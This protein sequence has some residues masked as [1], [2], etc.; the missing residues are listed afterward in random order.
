MW[1][2]VTEQFRAFVAATFEDL[3]R[4]WTLS[5]AQEGKLPFEPE[6]VGS[7]WAAD[8]QVDVVALDW[9]TKQILL[10][11]AKW[12]EG[13]VGREVI[14][15]L[16]AKTP[17][18][19]PDGGAGWRVYYAFFA[20]NGFTQAAREEAQPYAAQLLTW[21]EMEQQLKV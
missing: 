16:I 2:S 8:A 9:R 13:Q 3:C 4:T 18:V 1:A 21:A 12:G 6:V 5:Q 15:E 10:G 19:V 17:K 7:H 20:R 14:R 11:E